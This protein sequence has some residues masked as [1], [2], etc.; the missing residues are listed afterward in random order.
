MKHFSVPSSGGIFLPL[1][2]LLPLFPSPSPLI[3]SLPL[4]S[5]LPPSIPPSPPALPPSLLPSLLPL[6]QK[7][8]LRI[9]HI[10]WSKYNMLK[11]TSPI[12]EIPSK[13]IP[14]VQCFR[15]PSCINLQDHIS[16]NNCPVS[17]EMTC[18]PV[19]KFV[20]HDSGSNTIGDGKREH[21]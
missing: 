7:A 3:L 16:T 13:F 12:R 2:P 15:L 20:S 11:R 17:W 4:P 21:A 14:R 19:A 9:P 18:D 5:P 1:S 6:Y 10:P 8:E